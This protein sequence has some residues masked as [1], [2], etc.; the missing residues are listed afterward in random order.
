MTTCT[1][2]EVRKFILKQYQSQLASRN[3]NAESITDGFD[4]LAEGI[5][6]SLGVLEMVSAIEDA[7]QIEIDLEGI[8]A[9]HVTVIG[10]LAAYIEKS[11]RPRQS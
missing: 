3:L 4:L 7:F 8:D 11:A 5:I 10:P 9:E 6:D 1:A 2:D